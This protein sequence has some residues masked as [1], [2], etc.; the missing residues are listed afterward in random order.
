VTRSA[1]PGAGELF[2]M[3]R[4]LLDGNDWGTAF[5]WGRAAAVLARQAVEL[6]LDE[7]WA[8][9]S[10]PM[11]ESSARGQFLALRLYLPDED[12]AAEGHATWSLLSRACHHH[13]YDLQPTR[14]EVLGWIVAAERFHGVLAAA[15]HDI[16]ER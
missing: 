16:R 12:M 5:W 14:D 3:C 4:T 1:A 10:P 15:G 8:Q 13:P 9:R 6:S 11:L 7:F 2:A